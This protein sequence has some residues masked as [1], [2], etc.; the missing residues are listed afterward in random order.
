MQ[1]AFRLDKDANLTLPT[2]HVFPQ[3]LPD[4]FSFVCT[5]RQRRLYKTPWHLIRVLDLEEKPQFLITLNPRRQSIEF[6]II[7]YEGRLQTLIF[8]NVHVSIKFQYIIQN[9]SC[10]RLSNFLL[11][12][13]AYKKLPS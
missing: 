2:R 13:P 5:Y 12:L 9:N 7:N 3:G 1:T 6:S 11:S 8:P 4:Q 10:T